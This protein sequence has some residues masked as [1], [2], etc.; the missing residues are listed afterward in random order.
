MKAYYFEGHKGE[1]IREAAIPDDIVELAKEKRK[2]LIEQLA[3]VDPE[4]EDLFLKEK[5]PSTEQ[6]RAAIRR[7]TISLKFAPVF[8][9]SA[10]KN[11]GVQLALDGVLSFLPN[12]QEKQNEGFILKNEVETKIVFDSD[13]KKPFVGYAF[14]LEENKFGQLT[15]VRVYQGRLKKGDYI[16]NSTAK[17]RMKISRMVKMHANEMQDIDS[18]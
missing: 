4:I 16:F 15:Y 14:K 18:A 17:K 11:K 1:E 5:E 7:T 6:I 3:D 10:Y 8:M 9:G 2:E 13:L 12:P